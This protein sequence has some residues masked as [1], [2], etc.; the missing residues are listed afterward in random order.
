[1]IWII[2]EGFI[3][4]ESY[5]MKL[6][7]M[8]QIILET[9]LSIDNTVLYRSHVKNVHSLYRFYPIIFTFQK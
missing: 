5:C 6:S 8:V 4:Y 9:F 7:E 1:M 2:S 3:Q